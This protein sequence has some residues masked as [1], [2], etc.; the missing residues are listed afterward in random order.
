MTAVLAESIYINNK[1]IFINSCLETSSIKLIFS[2]I[3]A[4]NQYVINIYS[5]KFIYKIYKNLINKILEDN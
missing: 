2:F 1:I 4:K 5:N 3:L